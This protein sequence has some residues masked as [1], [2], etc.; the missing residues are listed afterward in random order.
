MSELEFNVLP[1]T[2]LLY[3]DLDFGFK[4]SSQDW[5]S[6]DSVLCLLVGSLARY[7]LPSL[8]IRIKH[9]LVGNVNQIPSGFPYMRKCETL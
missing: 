9:T 5:K 8:L 2:R 4:L 1:T 7:P 6:G 3:T